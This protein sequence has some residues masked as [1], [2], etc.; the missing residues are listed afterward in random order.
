MAGGFTPQ[1]SNIL[2]ISTSTNKVYAL[3]VQTKQFCDWCMG[4]SLPRKFQ[5]FPGGVIGLSFQQTSGSLSVIIY[6][7][8]YFLIS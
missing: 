1:N 3:D 8:R 4:Y 2:I 7:P 5:E 6:S